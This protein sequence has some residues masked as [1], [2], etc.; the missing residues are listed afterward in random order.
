MNVKA[1]RAGTPTMGIAGK[2]WKLG[3][4]TSRIAAMAA[5]F[6]GN[7]RKDAKIAEKSKNL[8]RIYA[9]VHGSNEPRRSV[10]R[11]D[12]WFFCSLRALRIL[13]WI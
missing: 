13:R 6:G 1:G 7:Q 9:D 4:Y 8:P 11:V 5:F 3:Q 12:P 2:G 10:I